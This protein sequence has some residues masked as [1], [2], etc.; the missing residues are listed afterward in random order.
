[1]QGVKANDLAIKALKPRQREYEVSV[2]EHR[3]LIVVVYPSGEKSFTLR[4]RQDGILKRIRLNATTL[5][6]ARAEWLAQRNT[7]K[8]GDDPFAKIQ[9]A[10]LDKKLKRRA[11]RTDP[12]IDSLAAD[13]IE[14]YAR[15]KKRSWQGDQRMLN[16]VVLKEWHGIKAKELKRRDV[17]D[18]LHRIAKQTPVRANRVLAVIRKMF[19]WAVKHEY[20][21]F[22]P[23]TGIERPGAEVSRDRVLSDDEIKQFWNGL[24]DSGLLPQTQIALKLQLTTAQRIGEIVGATWPEFDRKKREWV[25]PGMRAKN[26]CENLVP[27]SPLAIQLLSELDR[28]GPALFPTDGKDGM[29]RT[30][31][32]SHDLPDAIKKLKMAHFT[33]HDLRR[34]AA[35]QLAG[36]GTMPKIID[37][38]LNHKDGSVGA[39]YNRYA[40]AH[41]K[42]DALE[43]WAGKLAQIV[44]PEESIAGVVPFKRSRR[45]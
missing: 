34:T 22:S 4:Y 2:R 14:L 27:L 40:Y 30:D 32:V 41:E 31:V 3:G 25:I 43:A 28:R 23:C 7:L 18:F 39:I 13:F 35:T 45:R 19:N 1:M 16:N 12:T 21:E 44:S 9:S 37:A 17:I 42:R 29:L 11:S 8:A 10:R 38:I 36:L 33:S 5:A 26:G 20:V 15:P 24:P 6:A